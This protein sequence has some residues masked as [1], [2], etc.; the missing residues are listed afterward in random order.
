M[1]SSVGADAGK[2]DVGRDRTLYLLRETPTAKQ[3]VYDFVRT[4]LMTDL[5]TALATPKFDRPDFCPP[6]APERSVNWSQRRSF[7]A[8]PG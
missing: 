5:P 1:I 8:R 2:P 3:A 7:Q 4:G 6:E